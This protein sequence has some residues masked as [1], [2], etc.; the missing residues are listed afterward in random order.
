[1]KKKKLNLLRL[2]KEANL[3]S[4]HIEN[5]EIEELYGSNDGKTIGTFLE[6]RFQ[7]Y[8]QHNYIFTQGNSGIGIDFPE[9]Q[10]DIKTTSCAQPQSSCPFQSAK[11][12][13]YGLGYHLLV[14]VYD[15]KDDLHTKKSRISV[16]FTLFIHQDQTADYQTTKGIQDILDRGGNQDDIQAFLMERHLPLDDIQLEQLSADIVKNPPAL[17]YLTISNALQWRLQYKRVIE[18]AGTTPGVVRLR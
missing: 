9:L 10:V 11:Q 3:F 1:M 4:L 12:K 15:K 7:E 14:F 8:L 13:I 17:G 5:I 16:P 18:L 6:K 2:Q